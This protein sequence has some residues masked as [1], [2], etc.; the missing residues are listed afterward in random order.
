MGL[1]HTVKII[2]EID[3][4]DYERS[5]ESLRKAVADADG[6]AQAGAARPDLPTDEV[7]EICDAYNQRLIQGARYEDARKS[8]GILLEHTRRPELKE[9]L[10]GRLRRLELVGRPA[11]PIRGV[12]LEGNPFDLS[13][14]AGKEAV[15][16]V[17]WA[18]WCLPCESE[19]EWLRE[20][21]RAYRGRGLQIVGINLDAASD[22]DRKPSTVLPNVRRFLLDYNVTWPTLMNGQG[23]QDYA[24]AYGVAEIP[25]NV[26]VGR[27]GRVLH[28]DLVR[29][30]IEPTIARVIGR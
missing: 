27:D 17:F 21:D 25:A 7:I 8:L 3:R 2:A 11:P 24:R 10:S 9:F 28:I 30:N 20:A 16:V 4:G 18:S 14:F 15:L 5:R 6:P 26:L 12:D 29:K 13:A 1:A 23:D 22:G 19:V